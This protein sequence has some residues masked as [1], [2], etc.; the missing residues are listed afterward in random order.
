[1]SSSSKTLSPVISFAFGKPSISSRSNSTGRRLS[2]S[3]GKKQKK[4]SERLFPLKLCGPS[5]RIWPRPTSSKR[6]KL[7]RENGAGRNEF[8]RTHSGPLPALPYLVDP[9]LH[10]N[11]LFRRLP[12]RICPR[13]DLQILWRRGSRNG[14][15]AD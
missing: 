5:S 2:M 7:R 3:F 11:H 15:P 1:Q 12:A 8:A 10:G 14:I 9:A 6:K 4:S 13:V